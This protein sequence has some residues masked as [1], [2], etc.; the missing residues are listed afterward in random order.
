MRLKSYHAS[1]K[2]CDEMR[3]LICFDLLLNK[4]LCI[5]FTFLEKIQ[6]DNNMRVQFVVFKENLAR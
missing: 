6:Q 2:E 5:L 4:S 3:F 1:Y